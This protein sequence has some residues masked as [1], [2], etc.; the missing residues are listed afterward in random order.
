MKFET[1]PVPHST[2]HYSLISLMYGQ[3]FGDKQHTLPEYPAD[4]ETLKQQ[5]LANHIEDF[6]DCV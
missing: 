3:Q 1:L 2:Q 4:L 6:C 5:D